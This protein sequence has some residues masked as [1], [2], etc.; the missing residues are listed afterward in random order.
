MSTERFK[1]FLQE[2]RPFAGLWQSAEFTVIAVGDKSGDLVKLQ[3][4]ASF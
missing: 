3:S 1:E 2:L 4:P